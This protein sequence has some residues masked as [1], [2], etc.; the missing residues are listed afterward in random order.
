[1]GEHSP[2]DALVPSILCEYAVVQGVEEEAFANLDSGQV[3]SSRGDVSEEGWE[4]LDW[5]TDT[6]VEK[7]CVSAEE[8]VT[9][10]IADSDDSGFWFNHYGTDWIKEVGSCFS[11]LFPILTFSHFFSLL[12]ISYLT[13]PM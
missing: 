5:V 3:S 10:L 12:R 9:A 11:F 6:R 1:M 7:A 2:C 8:V 13:P 4:R